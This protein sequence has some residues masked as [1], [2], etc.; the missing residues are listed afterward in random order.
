M[1]S[2]YLVW[3]RRDQ[4][5]WPIEARNWQEAALKA[6]KSKALGNGAVLKVVHERDIRR[7]EVAI[8]PTVTL[9]IETS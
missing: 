5:P 8:E 4:R 2:T 6:A 7:F 3:A 9:K 1:K